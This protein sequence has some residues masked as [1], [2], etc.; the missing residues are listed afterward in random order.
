M[1]RSKTLIVLVLT[2]LLLAIPAAHAQMMSGQVT[3]RLADPGGAVITA[4]KVQFVNE[5][6]LQ[7]REFTT[8]GSGN[9]TFTNVP[10]GN[11]KLRV[12]I[13]GFKTYEQRGINVGAV[14]KV[15]LPEIVL[16]V[17]DVSTSVEVQASAVR[18]STDSSDRGVAINTTQIEDTVTKGRNFMLLMATLPGVQDLNQNDSRGWGTGSPTLMGGQSGQKLLV[19]DGAASQDSGNR[20]F[21]YIAPSV[22][23]I[24][25]VRVLVANFNAEYGARSG[26][27]MNIAIK[28]GTK[29][30]HGSGYYFVRNEALNANEFFNNKTGVAR[31][32][33]KYHNLGGTIGGP[34]IIPG[35]KF[36]KDRNKLFWFFSYD[37]LKT[38]NVTGANRYTMPTAL[39]RAGDYSATTTTTGVLI[40]IKDPLS[41]AVFPGNRIPAARIDR[42]GAAMMNL[43]P[44]PNTTDPT[45]QRQY[46]AE[47][48]NPFEQPRHDRILRVDYPI[49]SKASAY[50]RLLQDYTGNDGYGQILGALGDGWRQFPHGYDIPSAG[51]VGSLIYTFKPTLILETMW[52]ITR[53]HQMN[54]PTD[55]SLYNNSLL[56]LKDAQGNAVPLTRLFPS[57]NYLNLRPQINFGFPSGFT[58][59][60]AGQTIPNAPGYGFDSRWPFDGT[61]QVQT[62]SSNLTWVKGAHNIKAGVYLEKMARN[63]SVYST[64][65]IAGSYYFGSDTSSAVDTGYPY[66]NLISGGFFAYGEDS[67]KQVN[68]ARYT[69]WDWFVQDTW[70]VMPKLTIDAGIRFQWM[71]PLHT[72][73]QRMGLFNAASYDASKAGQPLYPALVNGVKR[74][75]NPVTGANYPFVLQGTY[76]PAS[77]SGMPFSGVKDYFGDF[78]KAPPI[79]LGPRVGFAYDPF[80]NGKTAIRGGFGIFYDRA[81]TV[82][83]IGALGVGRGPL[84][85]PPNFLAPTVLNASFTDLAG[86]RAV[87]SP[88]DIQGGSEEHLAPTTYN[89]S[90]GVQRDVGFGMV[91]D[92]AYV[93]N[94]YKHGFNGAVEDLNA[95]KPFTTWTPQGGTNPRFVDPT[96]SSGALYSSNLIRSM[97]GFKG[98]GAVPMF[99]ND[100]QSSYNSLQVQLN[101]R[102][103]RQLTWS[104]NYTWS[105]TLIYQR[106]QWTDDS[107]TRIETGNRPHAFNANFGYD[108][109]TVSSQGRLLKT[110]TEGWRLTGTAQIFSGAGIAPACGFTANPV[111]YPN[112]TPT[113]SVLF[114]CQMLNATQDALWLASGAKPSDV[115]STA[116]PRLWYPIDPNN[117]QLPKN[118]A[119][120]ARGIIGNMP[121]IL[122]YGPGTELFNLSLMKGIRIREGQR[123][124]FKVEATNALNHFN[125]ANP[126]MTLTRNYNTGANTNA[127]FGTIQGTQFQSRRAILSVR[128]SF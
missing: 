31:P 121:P 126:N 3:G 14:E 12:A 99:T 5:L 60:S 85:A 41:G 59:Q 69:Q 64:Y 115:G 114:R 98:V 123:M 47:F 7:T 30:F 34:F 15:A 119:P 37:Y 120:F 36:N 72:A 101:R 103:G 20:D 87:L 84:A 44:L 78:W 2:C 54:T 86:A 13:P 125:P 23:A 19:L 88:Q 82:D 105:K 90:F 106:Q 104:A 67:V 75:V 21:G 56:P 65:N 38:K 10:P 28:S 18:V 74:A 91:L 83:F 48:I 25:E 108:F 95:V 110:V 127:A 117:F 73:G 113:G 39:E 128:Y 93:A 22:D 57:S 63:V 62:I 42:T 97:V 80:G 111:G 89:W 116:D 107:L 102:V 46:N 32:R 49:S 8:D 118:Y 70:K 81:A 109:P 43:F 9:F 24:S 124:E 94:T 50:V 33:Y 52:G 92:V 71:G 11:Y 40:P 1:K 58:P 100:R 112:G 53:G 29:Q 17:G 68:H 55:Q 61:D 26:G 35:T 122:T 45:G 4:A 66:S 96:S 51:A 79:T 6:T 16:Q 77:Y 76:D 27:Q